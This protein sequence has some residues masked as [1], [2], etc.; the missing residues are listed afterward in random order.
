MKRR[1]WIATIGAVAVFAA[2]L[3]LFRSAGWI[4]LVLSGSTFAAIW[5]ALTPARRIGLRRQRLPDLPAGISRA[6]HEDALDRLERAAYALRELADRSRGSEQ[7]LF[8]RLCKEI[9]VLRVHHEANPG[10][11]VHTR[12]FLR[13][14]L[15]QMIEAARSFADLLRRSGDDQAGRLSD[16]REQIES[17]LP[18]LRRI[19]QACLENDLT[20]LEV[21]VDVLSQQLQRRP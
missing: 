14:H 11:I 3:A 4:S 2:T 18:V 9:D 8:R 13:H 20:A 5:L 7:E 19:G 16:I 10:H 15:P 21:H 12:T 17:F 1:E 6:D